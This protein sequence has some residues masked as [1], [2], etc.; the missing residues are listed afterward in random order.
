MSSAVD[1]LREGNKISDTTKKEFFE[2]IS[3]QS[4]QKTWE[5]Y[6]R[7]A[8]SNL[9]LPLTCQLSVSVLRRGFLGI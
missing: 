7:G 1:M 3:F 4:D 8:L 9:S 5:K 6:C 2:V